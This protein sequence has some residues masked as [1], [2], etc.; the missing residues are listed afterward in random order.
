MK[1]RCGFL[2]LLLLHSNWILHC[3]SADVEGPIKT[4]VVLVMENRSF[5]HML[6]WLKRLNPEIDGLTGAESNPVNASDPNSSKVFVTDN[7][8]FVDP[9]PGHSFSAIREQIFGKDS[10]VSAIPPPMNGFVQQAMSMNYGPDFPE[11]VMSGFRPEVIPV[12]TSLAMEFAVFDKWFA[13]LPTSTQPNRLYVHS[14]TSHGAISNVD[15]DL[16][17]GYPQKPIFE[18]VAEAGLSWGVYYQNIP[19]TLFLKDLRKLKNLLKFKTYS[20]FFKSDASAGKLPHYVVIEQRYFDLEAAPANDDHPSHDVAEG[21]KL[22]KE[23]YETLRASPQWN[24]TLFLI[25]YDEHGGFFDHVP[26]PVTSVPNPDGLNGP[27]PDF[28][29]FNR[30]GVRVPTIAISPWI[31]KGLVVHEPSGPTPYSHYEHSSIAATVKEIFKL[32]N[33]LTKRDEWAGT[34]QHLFSQRTEPRG[35]CPNELPTPPWSLR[36]VAADENRKLTQFQQELVL[37]ASQLTGDHTLSAYPFIGKNMTVKEGNAYVTTAVARFIGEG[38]KQIREGQD[39][40]KIL[41]LETRY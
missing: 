11:R 24:E 21:Q 14:A 39:E 3:N 27:A 17:A 20:P 8:E 12:S 5:D 22:M 29:P 38:M 1:I 13:S 23:V 10:D 36:H 30:L 33:F 15:A 35:D 16:A 25:T 9:D 37:L 19:A 7:A 18:S 40:S 34:F 2:L 32:P 4:V 6:G 28:F 26:T 41:Q 31:N